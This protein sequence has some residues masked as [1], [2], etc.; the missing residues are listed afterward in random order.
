MF[1]TRYGF[2]I[3]AAEIKIREE[4][5]DTFRAYLLTMIYPHMGLKDIR[6]VICRAVKD[7]PKPGNWGEN[8][9]MRSE[10]E[11][12]IMDAKWYYVY[13]AIVEDSNKEE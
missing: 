8:E 9:F 3:Q 11:G 2:K 4:T 10:I 6:S 12:L 13:D 5:S 7:A 1:S